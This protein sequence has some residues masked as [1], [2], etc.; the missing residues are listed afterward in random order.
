MI[1]IF[2][3]D[4]SKVKCYELATDLLVDNAMDKAPARRRNEPEWQPIFWPKHYVAQDHDHS[5]EGNQL[6]EAKLKKYGVQLTKM[7][8]QLRERAKALGAPAEREEQDME[9]L[10]SYIKK[11]GVRIHKGYFKPNREKA[12]YC[13]FVEDTAIPNRQR[14]YKQ[15]L[16]QNE[17]LDIIH[18]V[19]VLQNKSNIVA[20]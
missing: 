7:R 10:K 4:L 9:K 19:L 17:K 13:D 11:L 1:S 5:L 14:R 15:I 8:A 18:Q 12:R 16:S 6:S 3:D 2:S 20:K